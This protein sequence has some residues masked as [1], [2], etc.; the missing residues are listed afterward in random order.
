LVPSLTRFHTAELMMI[1]DIST[2]MAMDTSANMAVID[3]QATSHTSHTRLKIQS[4][5]QTRVR[6]SFN[7]LT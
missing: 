4:L 5:G 7:F 3:I 2:D 1:M 6:A